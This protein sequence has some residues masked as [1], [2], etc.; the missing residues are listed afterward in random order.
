[1]RS[2][3]RT[4]AAPAGTALQVTDPAPANPERPEEGFQVSSRDWQP[5]GEVGLPRL[6]T[7]GLLAPSWGRWADPGVRV[8]HWV[9]E[10]SPPL[11]LPRPMG[12]VRGRGVGGLGGGWAAGRLGRLRWRSVR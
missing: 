7:S 2:P 12:A 5:R 3:P 6:L 8:A 11:A 1:M 4:P 9:W 10:E